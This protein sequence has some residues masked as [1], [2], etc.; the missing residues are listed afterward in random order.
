MAAEMKP[1]GPD[2][3]GYYFSEDIGLG[4]RRLSIIDLAGGHQPMSDM[5]RS[6]WVAFNGE[7]Y[8]FRDL[9][10]ELKQAGHRF[11]TLSDTEVIVHGYREWGIHV[12]ERLN[13]MFGLAL[14]DE[15]ERRLLLVRD[16]LGIKPVYY[17]FGHAGIRFGSEIG[18]LL[19]VSSGRP[20]V[21]MVA[22]N[23]FL[24]YRYVPA[25]RTIF[26]GIKK[27]PAGS[28]LAI[29][30]GSVSE[31][32]FWR[33]TPKPF[34]RMPSV[35]EAEEQLLEVYRRSV[36]R[37][38]VSDVPLGLLLSGGVDSSLLLALMGDE[39]VG[40][41]TFSIG[42]G[43]ELDPSDELGTAAR[44]ARDMKA[45]N[46]STRIDQRAFEETLSD[47]VSVVEE[48]VATAS[49][50]PMHYVCKRA[51]EDVKVALIGQGPD[52]MLGGYR[53]HLGIRYGAWWRN[54][55]RVMRAPIGSV[56]RSLSRSETIRRGL[57]S[58]DE[59]D[60]L[61][62]YQQVFSINPGDTVDSLFYD[63][64]LPK[65]AGDQLFDCW[66]DIEPLAHDTDE[67]GGFSFY[68]LRSSLPDELLMY[69]D[70]I[71][72]SHSLE[73]RVPYLDHEL[74]EYVEQ[75]PAR[76]KIRRGV[77]KW[78]HRRVCK[79]LLPNYVL[80]RKKTGFACHVVDHW[81]R[82]SM[83]AR[84][85]ETFHDEESLIFKYL[86]PKPV[87]DL[88]HAHQCGQQDNHKVLFN[89][90]FLEEWLRKYEPA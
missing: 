88:F 66:R 63:G 11:S 33:Y 37:Q 15:R 75:L 68:E 6:V 89:L 35:R 58:L 4:F 38:L 81:F 82:S 87:T 48:P 32:R 49:I 43:K 70:K 57:D 84:L 86:R 77:Q 22:L 90:T 65:E 55:P 56:L 10:E 51:R 23:H 25:P 7:I 74:V 5:E 18:P 30:N 28:F 13:G 39:G 59:P 69:A 61:R 27:L 44:T 31:A 40:R 53:R 60:R 73:V 2:D 42:Y 17:R 8:N 47:L 34:D 14:W 85:S 46:V 72:M 41:K 83:N 64:S 1:R 80:R 79:K 52:E 36:R 20:E 45:E 21:D 78:L 26:K 12:L 19:K 9:R 54:V 50:V 16:R 76:F 24:R 67:L 62:R 29:Q 71:S 3:E